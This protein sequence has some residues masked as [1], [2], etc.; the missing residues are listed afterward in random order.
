ML[1]LD[2][3]LFHIAINFLSIIGSHFA[4]S[5]F[6]DMVEAGVFSEC[7]SEQI[8]HGKNWNCGVRA[9]KLTVEYICG[10]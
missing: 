7:V 9:H 6:V 1:L 4:Q 8:M 10:E 5:G 3:A 2:L